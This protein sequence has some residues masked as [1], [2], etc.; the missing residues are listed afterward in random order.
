[1]KSDT[2]LPSFAK[3]PYSLF[4]IIDAH[5]FTIIYWCISLLLS[6]HWC[7]TS[8]WR[9]WCNTSIWRLEDVWMY[10]YWCLNVQ[11]VVSCFL[12]CCWLPTAFIYDSFYAQPMHPHTC[13]HKSSTTSRWSMVFSGFWYHPCFIYIPQ[14]QLSRWGAC[15][16]VVVQSRYYASSLYDRCLKAWSRHLT[17]HLALF[18]HW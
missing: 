4:I 7:N 18:I 2:V 9:H 11:K 17:H 16:I 10:N 5:S 3:L 1:M 13:I 8:I 6:M 12:N 15:H 14:F